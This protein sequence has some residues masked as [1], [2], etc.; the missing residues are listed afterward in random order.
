ML[1]V[2]LLLLLLLLLLV[3]LLL[4]NSLL[5]FLLLGIAG[6]RASSDSGWRDGSI[7]RRR[8]E[9][10]QYSSQTIQ[11]LIL[12]DGGKWYNRVSYK[13]F[14][15]LVLGVSFPFPTRPR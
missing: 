14:H 7:G 4:P 13:S 1:L 6:G 11:V 9:A 5:F 12:V 3:L 2:F 8:S 10:A 15:L